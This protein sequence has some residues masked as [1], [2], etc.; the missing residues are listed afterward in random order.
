MAVTEQRLERVESRVDN[1]AKETGELRGAYVH[2][3]TK[4]DV[5]RATLKTVLWVVG[6]GLPGW[7]TLVMGFMRGG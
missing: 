5:T 3:A 1:L 7:V 2:L 4:E 6:I